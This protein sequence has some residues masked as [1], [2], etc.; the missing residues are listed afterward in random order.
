MMRA[1]LLRLL[2]ALVAVAGPAMPATADT[3]VGRLSPAI[4]GVELGEGR[5]QEHVGGAN[6][7]ADWSGLEVAAYLPHAAFSP[8][9]VGVAGQADLTLT[10]PLAE[11]DLAEGWTVSWSGTVASGLIDFD[12]H[13]AVSNLAVAPRLTLAW[14]ELR[15]EVAAE[16]DEA[17]G[18]TWVTGA[19]LAGSWAAVA[20]SVSLTFEEADGEAAGELVTTISTQL[21]R[22][23]FG[24]GALLTVDS[25][26]AL[27][28]QVLVYVAVPFGL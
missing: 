14:G 28:A 19:S 11:F 5:I 18:L 3:G 9:L 6:V 7:S 17:G 23:E 15:L 24:A 20:W 21:G 27:L 16:L 2:L 26:S 1:S 25:T 10:V 13:R 12:H 8:I 4:F 22:C